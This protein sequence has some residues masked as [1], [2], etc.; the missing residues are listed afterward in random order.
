MT[1]DVPAPPLRVLL[2]TLRP[3]ARGAARRRLDEAGYVVEQTADELAVLARMETL[4]RGFDVLVLEGD[5][6]HMTGAEM[7][8]RAARLQ[9]RMPVVCCT[10]RP[11]ILPRSSTVARLSVSS[12]GGHLVEAVERAVA[13]SRRK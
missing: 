4:D 7:A 10:D 1:A 8:D 13:R 6:R 3:S 12:V 5:F 9:P 11:K 2:L